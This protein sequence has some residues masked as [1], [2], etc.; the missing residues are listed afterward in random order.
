MACGVLELAVEVELVRVRPKRDLLGAVPPE[1][2]VR[3]DQVRGE[4]V[5]AKQVLLVALESVKG[6]LE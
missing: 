1:R 4:D 6:L 2:Q 3:L 5:A